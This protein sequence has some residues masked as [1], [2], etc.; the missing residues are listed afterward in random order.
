M[1]L[2]SRYE[3][4]YFDLAIVD[5]P[6]GIGFDGNV[7]ADKIFGLF[8]RMHT[9]VEGLGVGLY[10]ANTILHNNGGFIEVAGKINEGAEFKLYF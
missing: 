8:K 9:H 10:M 2:M 4:N 5:P 1:E 7:A 3:D 6:Y